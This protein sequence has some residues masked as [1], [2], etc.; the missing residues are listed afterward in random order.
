MLLTIGEMFTQAIQL[1]GM[2]VGMV[3]AVLAIFY[4]LIKLLIRLFPEKEGE[5]K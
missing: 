1:M 2:G 4:V 3:F 5:K